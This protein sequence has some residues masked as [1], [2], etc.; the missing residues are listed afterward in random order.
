MTF[1]GPD[2]NIL[3]LRCSWTLIQGLFNFSPVAFCTSCGN[4]RACSCASPDG[5]VS[6]ARV[7][8]ELV[9]PPASGIESYGLLTINAEPTAEK[10]LRA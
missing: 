7:C 1:Q 9:G 6:R 5:R 2:L 4:E 8:G 10:S 3:V